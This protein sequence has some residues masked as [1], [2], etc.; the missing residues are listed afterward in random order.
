M[1]ALV[2]VAS[3]YGAT[4]EIAERIGSVLI[5]EG[6]SVTVLDVGQVTSVEEYDVAVVGSAVYLGHWLKEAR[7]FVEEHKQTLAERPL[8]LFSSG[9]VGDPLSPEE[10]PVDV[11]GI[12]DATGARDH[13]VFA[14]RIE[15]KR[16]NFRERA[17]VF[18]LRVPDGDYR[19][20]AEIEGWATSI[21]SM[22]IPAEA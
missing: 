3:K 4:S 1:R 10:D 16:L 2:A 19:D 12:I 17:M 22:V 14:G 5:R 21:A 20:W 18:A 13:K 15:R 7:D 8:W 9:P 11:S 6:L